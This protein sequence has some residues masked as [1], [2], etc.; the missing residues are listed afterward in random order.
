[1]RTFFTSFWALL[2]SGFAGGIIVQIIAEKTYATEEFILAFVLSALVTFVVTVLFFIAQL[3]S[4]PSSAVG[5]LGKWLAILWGALVA[6]LLV[7][8]VASGGAGQSGSKEAWLLVALIVPGFVT[9]LTHF[10]F[11]RWRVARQPPQFGRGIA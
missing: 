5:T 4:N 11:V 8:V 6:A 2:I 1:M 7:F 10:W 9:I 3:R